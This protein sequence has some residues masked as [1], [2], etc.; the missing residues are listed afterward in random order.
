V[1]ASGLVRVVAVRVVDIAVAFAFAALIEQVHA[2]E[3][4][5]EEADRDQCQRGVRRQRGEQ[6]LHGSSIAAHPVT[7]RYDRSRAHRG[8]ER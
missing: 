8:A 1:P 6:E 3:R 7:N 2:V 5:A 4:E